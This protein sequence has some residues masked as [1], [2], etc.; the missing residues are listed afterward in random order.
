MST[1]PSD[2]SRVA[3]PED[4][5]RGVSHLLLSRPDL[6]ERQCRSA[7][8]SEP[9]NAYALGMLAVSLNNQNRHQEA[10]EAVNAA[11]HLAPDNFVGHNYRALV[12]M[13]LGRLPES[14]EAIQEA[15]RLAPEVA[16]N[17]DILA[18]IAQC[19]SDWKKLASAAAEAL[20]LDPD[21]ERC[22]SLYV[23][24]L[25]E[26]GRGEEAVAAGRQALE[27]HPNSADIHAELAES[28]LTR[29]LVD[30]ALEHFRQAL[31]LDPNSERARSGVVTALKARYWIYRV[32]Y[33]FF[34]IPKDTRK[35][36]GL[37][38]V[39][40]GQLAN[41]MSQMGHGEEGFVVAF[42]AVIVLAIAVTW[43]AEPVFNLL[44]RLNPTGRWA[45]NDRERRESNLVGVC[46]V[47]GTLS[48]VGLLTGSWLAV[49]S[50][51][52]I[53]V[54]AVPLTAY[55]RKARDSEEKQ[56]AAFLTLMVVATLLVG[57]VSFALSPNAT[58][59]VKTWPPAT[60]VSAGLFVFLTISSVLMSDPS[61][62]RR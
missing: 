11:V 8:A 39:I 6:V 12:L 40:V 21:H 47:M 23:L 5:I 51:L 49:V 36:S 62:F 27:H 35:F 24:A 44:L 3:D 4:R 31:Q 28:L 18:L 54:S 20:R 7:L 58:S 50:G 10:L 15:M 37:G 52:C 29:G 55:W 26:L 38:F 13:N 61:T 16:A 19:E 1:S 45:L 60:L 30:E 2:P 46:F 34:R 33:K 59:D 56:T 25:R 17:F 48:L 53:M 57:L 43:L 9:E 42:I 41:Q 14:N 22:A 32:S